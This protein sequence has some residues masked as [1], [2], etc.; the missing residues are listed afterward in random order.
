MTQPTLPGGALKRLGRELATVLTGALEHA[1]LP[2][3][4]SE[5]FDQEARRLLAEFE[6]RHGKALALATKAEDPA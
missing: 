4:S 1:D 6:R 2:G 5:S 3:Y